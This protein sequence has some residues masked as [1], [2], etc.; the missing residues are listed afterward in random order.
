MYTLVEH[1]FYDDP[2]CNPIEIEEWNRIQYSDSKKAINEAVG[3][4]RKKVSSYSTRWHK[5]HVIIPA[6]NKKDGIILVSFKYVPK[7]ILEYWDVNTLHDINSFV[8]S[9]KSRYYSEY[10]IIDLNN[11]P[12][13]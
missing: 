11:L 12:V 10:E 8:Y 6:I 5:K 2:D 9:D 13:R 3:I 7:D 1:I 4:E